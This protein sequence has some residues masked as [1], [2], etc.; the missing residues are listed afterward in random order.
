M[1]YVFIVEDYISHTVCQKSL[2]TSEVD[3]VN[4]ITYKLSLNTYYL[5][6]ITYHLGYECRKMAILSMVVYFCH[7]IARDNYH[8]MFLFKYPDNSNF[9]EKIIY[10]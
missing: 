4:A 5:V 2:W 10:I 1:I 7:E 3:P 8:H 9:P 6:L